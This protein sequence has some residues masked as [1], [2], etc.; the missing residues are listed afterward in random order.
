[1]YQQHNHRLQWT[2]GSPTSGSSASTVEVIM[3]PYCVQL[4]PSLKQLQVVQAVHQNKVM[5]VQVRLTII[6]LP[7]R[8][9]RTV[10]QQLEA[11]HQLSWSTTQQ[12]H[13][14]M[15]IVT[16]Y[17]RSPLRSVQTHL[18]NIT[19]TCQIIHH[20]CK[21]IVSS[22]HHLTSQFHFHHLLLHLL[23][24]QQ[25]LQLLHQT[26]QQQSPWWQMLWIKG[27]PIQQQSWMPCKG[28][29]H[30]LQ[31]HCSKPYRWELMYKQK[32]SKMQ[33]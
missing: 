8:V 1:M 21:C 7:N 29:Q 20:Q 19:C 28:P 33:G 6:C 13:K 30:S 26:C 31:M 16:M 25:L 5:L 14:D 11:Q 24:Y 23:M 3:N 32:R 4:R 17:H 15:Q 12:E 22:H 27:T 18:T 10:S 2:L 9:P